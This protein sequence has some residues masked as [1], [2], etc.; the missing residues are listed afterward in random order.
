MNERAVIGI[1]DHQGSQELHQ[2]CQH[3][4]ETHLDHLIFYGADLNCQTAGGNTPLHICAISNQ[5]NCARVL[6]F[7][8]ADKNIANYSNQTA[9][10]VAVISGNDDIAAL[11]AD[12]SSENVTVFLQKPIHNRRKRRE[13]N[14]STT[15]SGGVSISRRDSSVSLASTGSSISLS[16]QKSEL[17]RTLTL[18]SVLPSKVDVNANKENMFLKTRKTS[19]GVLNGG[20]EAERKNMADVEDSGSEVSDSDEETNKSNRI[21]RRTFTSAGVGSK[22]APAP[23]K[24]IQGI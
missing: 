22:R 8:G 9:Y 4:R 18:P 12:F 5:E 19:K 2:A 11:I 24:T 17:P 23:I 14:T 1:S 13:S 15:S 10:D 16:N 6:L 21:D 7:R 3:G 20:N